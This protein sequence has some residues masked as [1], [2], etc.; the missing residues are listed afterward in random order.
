MATYP[1]PQKKS[2]LPSSGVSF[3]RDA[4]GSFPF[5]SHVFDPKVKDPPRNDSLPARAKFPLF[6]FFHRN[7]SPQENGFT[8]P[9]LNIPLLRFLIPGPPMK[10]FLFTM[11][12][13]S[14]KIEK[15]G[16]SPPPPPPPWGTPFFRPQSSPPCSGAFPTLGVRISRDPMFLDYG[17]PF[18]STYLQ[19]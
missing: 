12:Y 13:D 2:F 19:L 4:P 15:F 6:P 14:L 18:F 17:D 7:C 3:S 11:T 10:P 8:S 9:F 1:F 5:F 16:F